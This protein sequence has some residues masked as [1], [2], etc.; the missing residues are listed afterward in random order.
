MRVRSRGPDENPGHKNFS[1]NTR[2]VTR[3]LRAAAVF[4]LQVV[5]VAGIRKALDWLIP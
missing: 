4:A 5:V 2:S 3:A 1:L